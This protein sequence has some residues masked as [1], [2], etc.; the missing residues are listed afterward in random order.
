MKGSRL[1]FTSLTLGAAL[2]ASA[3]NGNITDI[4]AGRGQAFSETQ[5]RAAFAIRAF[6][7]SDNKV[8]ADFKFRA[9]NAN[10]DTRVAIDLIKGS[11]LEVNGN[12]GGF[13]GPAK[14]TINNNG[15]ERVVRG[16]V[17]VKVFS[18]K[19]RGN[20]GGGNSDRAPQGTI[21]QITERTQIDLGNAPLTLPSLD[22]Q[23]PSI[24]EGQQD[25]SHRRRD[26]IEVEFKSQDLDRVF[27]FKGRVVHGNIVLRERN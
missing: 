20:S 22:F 10:R 23:V 14:F 5:S 25:R 2:L 24:T 19:R 18:M 21:G 6:K 4:I 1:I 9:I 13:A 11:R 8:R 3:Q 12:N 26:R 16:T 7:N 27:T 17:T 15:N